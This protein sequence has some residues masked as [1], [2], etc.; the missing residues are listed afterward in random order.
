MSAAQSPSP[1]SC[2]ETPKA[3]E[4]LSKLESR[5]EQL[6]RSKLG[7][8]SGAGAPCL[9]CQD[10]CPGLDLHFWRKV[11]RNCK[12]RKNQHACPEDDDA[13]G[14]A[15]FEILGQ[16][17]A[18]P[19]FIK[20]KA[21]ASQP[22][23]LEWVPPN[24]A[25]DVVTDY[26]EML[27]TAQIPV[28]GSDAA[29]KRKQQLELQ[30]PPHDLDAALCDGLTETEAR[31]LQQYVQRLREQCVGQGVVVRLG[32]R[33]NHAQV[34][35]VTPVAVVSPQET[36]KS[37][38]FLGLPP[39]ADATLNELL[40]N[41]KVAQALASPASAQP[42]LLVAF[43]EP[44]SDSTAQF[45]ENGGALR[46]QTKEK[47]LGISKPAL[48]SLVSHGVVYDKVLGVL[49]EKNL[50]ISRDPKLGPIAEFRKE[51][52]NN[53]QFR[54]DIN[55]I[56][57]SQ[58]QQQMTPIKSSPGTP[59]NSPLPLKNPVQA[60]FGAQMRQDTPMRRVKFGG[61]STVVYD[62]GLPANTDYERDPIF[63]QILQ[64]EPLKHALQEARSG[65]APSA[66]VISNIPAAVA[67]L[68][69]L[70]G[71]A[72]ATKAQLQ[73]MGLDKNMLQS[74][75]SNAPYY[76]RLFRSLQDKGIAH[77][78]CQLL[79]P[80]KQVHD[81]LLD[82]NQLLEDI[83]KV[84]ADMANGCR[85]ITYPKP[86]LGELPTSQSSDSGFHSKPSTPG[87]TSEDLNAN[88]G[89]FASI[90]GIEDMNMYPGCYG[91]PEQFQQLRLQEDEVAAGKDPQPLI[92]CR[93]CNEPIAYGEVAVKADRAGKEIAWHPG[94]FKCQ[95]CRELLADLV[96]FFHQG[97]VYCGRDLAI[98]LKIPRCRACDELIFT[99]EYTAA[100]GATF[101]IKHFCCYQCDEPLA[102][103][104][105][106]PDENSNM[107][108]CLQCYD[109][110]FAVACQRCRLAIGPADQGVAWGEIHWH[111]QCFVCAG[112]ECSKSLIGGRF[113]VKQDMPFCSP[114]CVRSVIS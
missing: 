10:K 63:A 80:L 2:V 48:Q 100:E 59:F 85:D 55:S 92:L 33:L 3:P 88:P 18:K 54:A 74:A 57:P 70:K 51:Y 32:N 77:D 97:Q 83:D 101:H 39:V 16:I 69:E 44:L 1:N 61:V 84:F 89:R 50:N 47:L 68:A 67:S 20:I 104:Q 17:R 110:F 86:I 15:Q 78:Q 94:C 93:D 26:M 12:C 62:C 53:P 108:L 21:L 109:R 105:Y 75:V 45:E 46:A 14:W 35:H 49:K 113:C 99:K 34:E 58:Q 107:P 19:A 95:T 64:A 38:Q 6:K 52:V 30:V 91:M 24:A 111:G 11:C 4:W 106:V 27:G 28:A 87:Y 90:P 41:P 65:R 8:E 102:G 13:T 79:Q 81:W 71:L 36:A 7:H 82:D 114:A 37:W 98:K 103:Q 43:A 112:V 73:S 60:R 66:V 5:R 23:Q 96:Y 9:E 76:D 25:P 22:V 29:I 56:C 40:A 72:P 31:Q 42:R